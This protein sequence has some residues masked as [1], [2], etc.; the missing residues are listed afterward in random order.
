MRVRKPTEG[1]VLSQA[2]LVLAFDYQTSNVI[3]Q[4]METLVIVQVNFPLYDTNPVKSLKTLGTLD[5]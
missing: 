1:V 3:K 4:R 5:F 2:S